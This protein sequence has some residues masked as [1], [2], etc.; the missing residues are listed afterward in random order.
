[1]FKYALTAKAQTRKSGSFS[2]ALPNTNRSAPALTAVLSLPI[3]LIPPPTIGG[4]GISLLTSAI[5]N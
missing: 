2:I 3:E 4:Y 1:M 5:T